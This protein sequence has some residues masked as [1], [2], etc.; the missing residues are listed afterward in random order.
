MITLE[1]RRPEELERAFQRAVKERAQAVLMM[2]SP[3]LE[4]NAASQIAAL[5]AQNR[6]PIAGVFQFHSEAG[7][8]L[9][10]GPD[11][12][13]LIRRSWVYADRILKGEKPANLPVQRPTKF[14]LVLNLK[15]AKALGITFPQTLLLQADNV[16][17]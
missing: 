1:V 11:L 14:H 4:G 13:D 10:Y 12:D 16:I 3:M 17:K 2:Q 5:A 7:F 9:S 8:L 6:L 15:T